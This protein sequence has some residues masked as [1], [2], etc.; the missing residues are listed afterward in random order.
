MKRMKTGMTY[1]ALMTGAVAALTLTTPGAVAAQDRPMFE[2]PALEVEAL[3]D[4]AHARAEALYEAP[5]RW[6]EAG[7]LHETAAE[8][9]P[10]ND[11]AQ[12]FGF[13]QAAILY[14]HADAP[15]RARRAMAKAASVAEATGDVIVAA[16]AWVDAA[17][18]AIDEGYPGKRREFVRRAGN[19]AQS[20]LL[21]DE[22]RREILNRI[23]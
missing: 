14:A 9:L 15:A 11:A 7:E 18:L 2:L 4:E 3:R 6:N 20:E 13:R 1:T 19:L 12:Y 23:G 22:E 10:D 5:G 8:R 17:F 21:S 16:H